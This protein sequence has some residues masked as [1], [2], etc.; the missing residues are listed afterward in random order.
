LNRAIQ[1]YLE[2]PVAEEILKGEIEEG[3]T[4]MAD[5]EGT[6]DALSIKIKKPKASSKEKKSE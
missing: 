6:G 2:D 5:Y 4:I 1:R 3:G